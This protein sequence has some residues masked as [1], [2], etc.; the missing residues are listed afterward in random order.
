ML[1]VCTLLS[2]SLIAACH[3]TEHNDEAE[4][5]DSIIA[6]C[7]DLM[8]SAPAKADSTLAALQGTLT[9]SASWYKAEV[10]RGTSHQL[11]GDTL[12]AAHHYARVQHWCHTHTGSHYIEGLLWNH[13][14]V[15]AII[16]GKQH[17]G[18]M[19]Y[20]RAFTLLNQPPKGREL[21]AVTINLA[22]IYMQSGKMPRAAH[23]YRYALFLCDSLHDTRSRASI[24]SGL[25]QV[26]MELENYTEAHKFFAQAAQHIDRESLQT[27]FFYHFSLGNCYY[28]EEQYNQALKSLP[29]PDSWRKNSTT[30]C[31]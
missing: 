6:A 21:I 28:Y 18:R 22:D 19:C 2:C 15:N 16:G 17:E 13:R 29:R 23:Y 9:D 3:G 14:G 11:L 5:A 1:S 10:F 24:C 25:G 7:T 26:Y 12:R 20:E 27:Q 30:K 8:F 4:R 31:C